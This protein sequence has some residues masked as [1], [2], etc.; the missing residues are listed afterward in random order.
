MKKSPRVFPTLLSHPHS[1][2]VDDPVSFDDSPVQFAFSASLGAPSLL[3]SVKGGAF[4]HDYF[5]ILRISCR[6]SSPAFMRLPFRFCNM[7]DTISTRPIPSAVAMLPNIVSTLV[8]PTSR[9]S[10]MNCP[11]NSLSSAIP[12]HTR[13]SQGRWAE[14]LSRLAPPLPAAQL[15]LQREYLRRVWEASCQFIRANTHPST[16]HIANNEGLSV[17]IGVPRTT[18]CPGQTISVTLR[19]CGL[20]T[21]DRV[22]LTLQRV[23]HCQAGIE[24]E[25]EEECVAH[26]SQEVSLAQCMMCVIP[27]SL[28]PSLTPQLLMGP[29]HVKWKLLFT[30]Y[31][32]PAH[33]VGQKGECSLTEWALPLHIIP[34]PAA[35]V[36]HPASP[37]YASASLHLP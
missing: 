12:S 21:L 36:A 33:W 2:A 20:V 5:I 29:V 31:S 9:A 18:W 37:A 11:S 32:S 26:V 27:V 28:P 25:R 4:S 17:H 1:V 15:C 16:Y 23:E 22:R 13:P 24:L 3:S 6:D 19:L 7:L 34:S 14:T 8:T 35:A 10:A 30:F